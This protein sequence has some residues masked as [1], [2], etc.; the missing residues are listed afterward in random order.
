MNELNEFRGLVEKLGLDITLC[1][2]DKDVKEFQTP[3]NALYSYFDS[4]NKTQ[5]FFDKRGNYIGRTCEGKF[6]ERGKE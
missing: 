2:P 3:E 4:L 5:Y 1:A 6:V